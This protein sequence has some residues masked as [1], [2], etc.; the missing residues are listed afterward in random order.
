MQS[1]IIAIERSCSFDVHTSVGVRLVKSMR[2]GAGVQQFND[3]PSKQAPWEYAHNGKSFWKV[4]GENPE[5]KKDFDLYMAARREGGLVPDWFEL[6]PVGRELGHT[7][8]EVGP[9]LKVGKDD[10]LFVDVAGGRGHDV[11]KFRKSFP[12]LPGRCILQDLPGTIAE[13]K[14]APPERVEL[15]EYDFFTPQPL[16]GEAFLSSPSEL[17]WETTSSYLVDM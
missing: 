4:L 13:V 14:Q 10:V 16:K 9:G 3:A 6:Y 2:T 5:H 12:H 11:T 7:T 1:H 15:M 17:T 8:A